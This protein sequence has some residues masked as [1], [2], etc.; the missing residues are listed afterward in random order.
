MWHNLQ[1]MEVLT[2]RA[3]LRESNDGAC[4]RKASTPSRLKS[5]FTNKNRRDEVRWVVFLC[6]VL[7]TTLLGL[8]L[9][10]LSSTFTSEIWS[11]NERYVHSFSFLLHMLY[12]YCIL[13]Q[14]IY[15][16]C[17]KK[18]RK[19]YVYMMTNCM[20]LSHL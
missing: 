15:I 14:I 16:S 9:C 19:F 11:V 17:A 13:F 1:G 8:T 20:F 10:Y 18:I 5:L 12:N 2:P 7:L 6:S 3:P 4:V